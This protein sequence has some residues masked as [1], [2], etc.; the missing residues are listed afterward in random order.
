MTVLNCN[1]FSFHFLFTGN[2]NDNF[3]RAQLQPDEKTEM[4]NIFT[5]DLPI[6]EA[7]KKYLEY[8]GVQNVLNNKGNNNV[9]YDNLCKNTIKW[10]NS[11]FKDPIPAII[12][13][14][15]WDY[16][17]LKPFYLSYAVSQRVLNYFNYLEA[18]NFEYFKIKILNE[19]PADVNYFLINQFKSL[20]IDNNLNFKGLKNDK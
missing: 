19:H 11:E 14:D 12:T 13:V 4:H 17:F 6:K 2:K 5:M 20:N 7:Y 1:K 3:C 18:G 9:D 16:D 8:E 15:S 10:A